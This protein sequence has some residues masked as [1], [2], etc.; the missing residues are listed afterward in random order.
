MGVCATDWSLEAADV[1]DVVGAVTGAAGAAGEAAVA[2]EGGSARWGSGCPQRSAPGEKDE[3]V[4]AGRVDV[5]GHWS[6]P[7]F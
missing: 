4:A 1:A 3:F 6:R 2:A 5:T 7:R